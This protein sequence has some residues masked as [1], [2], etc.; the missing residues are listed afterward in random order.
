MIPAQIGWGLAKLTPKRR[1]DTL[2][3]TLIDAC[4][5]VEKFSTRYLAHPDR[6]EG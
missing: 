6:R 3:W 4:G 5:R 2:E 1:G